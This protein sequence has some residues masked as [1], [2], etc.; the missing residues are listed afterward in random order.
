MRAALQFL[1][2]SDVPSD[3]KAVL[4]DSL[5][6]AMREHESA[7]IRQQAA[8]QAG[9]QW[10]AHE[11]TQLQSFLQ[12]KVANSWQQAD[13]LL[14]Q[15]AA[16]LHRNPRDVRAKATELGFGVGVDYHLARASTRSRNE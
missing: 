4:I 9:G 10:Q 12:G 7:Q 6:Q 15:L 3:H 2:T 8:E 5:L 14:M 13:E 16:Q 11:T 1:I